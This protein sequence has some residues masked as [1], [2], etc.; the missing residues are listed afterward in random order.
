MT[1]ELQRWSEAHW[2]GFATMHSDPV[3]MADLGGPFDECA[4]RE[5]FDRYR[6]AWDASGISRWAIVD[7]SGAFLGYAGIMLR[8]DFDHPLGSHHEVGWRLCRSAW[9][10]GIATASANQALAHAWS[11][12]NVPEIV[13]YTAADNIRSQNVMSRLGL[14]RDVSRDFTA[15]YARGDWTGLVWVAERP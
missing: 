8:S 15:R 4:S 5:K 11:V 3:V 1:F 7:H 13:S 6:N 12:L 2:N 14:K 10:N 9:G